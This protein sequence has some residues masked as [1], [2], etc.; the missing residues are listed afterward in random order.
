M[1]NAI[2]TGQA[3]DFAN[4]DLF[5]RA[6]PR[7]FFRTLQAGSVGFVRYPRNLLTADF[8]DLISLSCGM[9][10][11]FRDLPVGFLLGGGYADKDRN[12]DLLRLAFCHACNLQYAVFTKSSDIVNTLN[13]LGLNV[14]TGENANFFVNHFLNTLR[15]NYRSPD[16]CRKS[17][18]ETNLCYFTLAGRV[19]LYDLPLRLLHSQFRTFHHRLEFFERE[20]GKRLVA[21]LGVTCG[22]LAIDYPVP[23]GL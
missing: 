4:E 15:R 7:Q 22:E 8:D 18:G 16:V 21:V 12:G 13:C 23:G 20:A 10:G 6:R 5:H 11:Q 1:S 17:G 3:G 9:G 19:F 14:V 2:A